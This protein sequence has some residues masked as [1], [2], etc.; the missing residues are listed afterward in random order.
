MDTFRAV[1]SHRYEASGFSYCFWKT[2]SIKRSIKLNFSKSCGMIPLLLVK[3]IQNNIYSLAYLVAFSQ[4]LQCYL[5]LFSTFQS[6]YSFISDSF[7]LSLTIHTNSW[8]KTNMFTIRILFSRKSIKLSLRT[9]NNVMKSL[10]LIGSLLC[11]ASVWLDHFCDK[12]QSCF[13]FSYV[14]FFHKDVPRKTFS[15]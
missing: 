10:A 7:S 5:C 8:R 1:Y 2:S 4:I 3:L 12:P 9:F 14:I 11:P 6:F 13:F 15:L